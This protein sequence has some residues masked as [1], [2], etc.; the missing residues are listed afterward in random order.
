[1]TLISSSSSSSSITTELIR[2]FSHSILCPPELHPNCLRSRYRSSRPAR[3][4]CLC[5]LSYARYGWYVD[6]F[7]PFVMYHQFLINCNR[8]FLCLIVSWLVC[9][10][11]RH[12][13]L[14]HPRFPGFYWRRSRVRGLSPS[15]LPRLPLDPLHTGGISLDIHRARTAR[16]GSRKSAE[17]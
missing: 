1:M 12:H 4:L 2:L 16:P 5:F 10:S 7:S 9:S 17:P 3:T 14:R 13:R 6:L 15:A 11:R 8:Y